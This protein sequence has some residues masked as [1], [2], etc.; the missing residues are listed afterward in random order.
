MRHINK[1]SSFLVLIFCLF[2]G[3]MPV[4]AQS[5]PTARKVIQQARA[6]FLHPGG[7]KLHFHCKALGLYNYSGDMLIKDNK[8]M[9]LTSRH[10]IWN[11]GQTAWDLDKN[12][13]TVTISNPKNAQ[14]NRIADQLKLIDDCDLTMESVGKCWR[15][16]MKPRQRKGFF[17]KGEVMITK[18]NY[19]P[20]QLRV[21]YLHFWI[22]M[23][24]S[25]FSI[26]EYPDQLFTFDSKKHPN[27]K[28]IDKR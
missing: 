23:D 12:K 11:N 13:Q 5:Q 20:T 16:T 6:V 2:L 17:S 15:I 18:S 9:M 19:Y 10:I 7:I 8:S 28:I 24:I 4:E 22:T 27:V 26:Q 21:K 3:A 14:N 1:L 25:N